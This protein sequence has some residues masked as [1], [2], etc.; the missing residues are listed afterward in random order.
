MAGIFYQAENP[1]ITK[2]LLRPLRVEAALPVGAL[3]GVGP[4]EI[5]LGLY[6]VQ[7]ETARGI[8]VKIRQ[9]ICCGGHG[10]P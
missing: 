8:G 2:I 5:P 3:V 4:E 7:R 6:E 9:G 10:D 1:L